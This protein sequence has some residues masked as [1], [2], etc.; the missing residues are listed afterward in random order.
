MANNDLNSVTGADNLLDKV[1]NYGTGLFER[2]LTFYFEK[3]NTER[4]IK[5]RQAETDADL[6]RKESYNNL[7]GALEQ[8]NIANGTNMIPY[9]MAGLLG[10]AAFV[11]VKRK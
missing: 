11:F 7:G 10:L 1:W 3:E 8:Y 6:A 2:G 4:L 9:L 5:L